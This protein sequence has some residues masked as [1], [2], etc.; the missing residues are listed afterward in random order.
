[1]KVR[2]CSRSS[3][4]VAT[5]MSS[6]RVVMYRNEASL[7]RAR[8]GGQREATNDEGGATND[9]SPDQ[10]EDLTAAEHQVPHA[11]AQLQA[12]VFELGQG[13]VGRLVGVAF[14]R[15]LQGRLVAQHFE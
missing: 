6:S 2:I 13:T 1:M 7:G 12:A 15:V 11:V 4:C 9:E 3:A 14:G 8:R 5:T 10:Q